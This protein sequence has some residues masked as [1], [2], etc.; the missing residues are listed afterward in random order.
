VTCAGDEVLGVPGFLRSGGEGVNHDVAV[1]GWMRER[2]CDEFGSR[3]VGVRDAKPEHGRGQMFGGVD[4]P[5]FT[6]DLLGSGDAGVVEEAIGVMA[7]AGAELGSG[8]DG[9]PHAAGAA[10]EVEG[11]V[12]SPG[13]DGGG[14]GR[15]QFGD[16]WIVVEDA[17]EAVF[18]DD[19]DFEI[20]AVVLEERECGRGEDA[21]A[22]GAKADHRDACAVR[23]ALENVAHCWLYLN[24]LLLRLDASFVDQH[25][26]DIIADGVDALA[27]DAFEAG[28]VG[29]HLQGGF[30]DGAHQDVEQIFADRH[31][32]SLV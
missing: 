4:G 32:Y 5:F 23:Q 27:L 8:G 11:H 21:I 30:A 31:S 20:G 25:H 1:G 2:R 19:G 9:E 28:L 7:K 22:E 16:V 12:R 10:V 17:A 18:D 3:D 29:L 6:E 14:L 13:G 15:K 26:G 24:S